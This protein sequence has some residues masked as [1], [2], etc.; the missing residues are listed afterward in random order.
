MHTCTHTHT[1]S[2]RR[3]VRKHIHI[4]MLT[5][6]PHTPTHTHTHTRTQTFTSGLSHTCNTHT[7]THTHTHAH[8][9]FMLL[10]FCRSALNLTTAA[11]AIRFTVVLYCPPTLSSTPLHHCFQ[12]FTSECVVD[13]TCL[14]TK[15][16]N[17]RDFCLPCRLGLL[18]SQSGTL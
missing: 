11:L 15:K 9:Y 8:T 5:P 17:Y 13:E 16:V 7:H 1:N 10:H 2:M 14:Y 18:N 12:V 6:T 3:C 4:H